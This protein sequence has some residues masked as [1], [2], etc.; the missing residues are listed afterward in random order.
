MCLQ[1]SNLC[2]KL[3][4]ICFSSK[5]F[6]INISFL[7]K[8]TLEDRNTFDEDFYASTTIYYCIDEAADILLAVYEGT[9]TSGRA[10]FE[11]LDYVNSVEYRKLILAELDK[12]KTN[13]KPWNFQ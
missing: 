3:N 12:N 5:K 13:N 11:L 7:E 8:V 4:T 1:S 10:E 2:W 9:S 6:L